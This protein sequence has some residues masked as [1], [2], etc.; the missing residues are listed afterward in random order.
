MILVPLSS[1]LYSL[2]LVCFIV[3]A[4]YGF[5]LVQVTRRSRRMII[6]TQEGP[7]YVVGGLVVL[8]IS[9]AFNL[10]QIEAYFGVLGVIAQALLMSSAFMFAKGFQSIYQIYRN[11]NVRSE[12]Y[13]TLGESEEDSGVDRKEWNSKFR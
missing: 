10:A 3:A 5:K 4:Y 8:G 7:K 12:I 1:V 6:I 9:Q 13:A 11:Q 2:A